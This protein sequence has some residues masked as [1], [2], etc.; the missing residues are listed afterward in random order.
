MLAIDTNLIVRYLVGDD[1]NQAA[2]ARLLIDNNDIF[3]CTTAV[4]ETEWVLRRLYGL[5]PDE[6]AK[7]L[8]A[9][10]GLPRVTIE[11]AA[12][13][14]R[15]L[16]WTRHGMDFADSLH[17]ATAEG[18]DAFITFDQEFARAANRLGGIKVRAP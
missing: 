13:V 5:S 10:A 14:G 1:R 17:L 3:V 4:L 16:E 8:A 18:C 12:S 9:F 15:A 6:C 7:V 11:D 2:K